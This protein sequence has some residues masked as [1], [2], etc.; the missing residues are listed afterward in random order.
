MKELILSLRM[1]SKCSS[2]MTTIAKI[3]PCLRTSISSTS[4]LLHFIII[5]RIQDLIFQQNENC[6]HQKLQHLHIL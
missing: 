1:S 6:Y 2:L 5:R 3:Y 4:L